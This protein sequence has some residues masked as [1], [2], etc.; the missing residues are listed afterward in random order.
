[1]GKKPKQ[2]KQR[3]AYY[4]RDDGTQGEIYIGKNIDDAACGEVLQACQGVE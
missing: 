1:M 2:P 3:R 4:T